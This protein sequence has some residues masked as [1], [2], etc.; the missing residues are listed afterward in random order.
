MPGAPHKFPLIFELLLLV[1]YSFLSLIL[2]LFGYKYFLGSE[3]LEYLVVD[4][5]DVHTQ[6]FFEWSI[7]TLADEIYSLEH[8]FLVEEEDQFFLET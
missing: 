8:L 6:H 5:Q 1:S 7:E 2:L 4:F 3:M